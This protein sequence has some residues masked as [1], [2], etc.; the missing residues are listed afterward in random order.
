MKR[1]IYLLLCMYTLCAW[2]GAWVHWCI[3]AWVNAHRRGWQAEYGDAEC[4]PLP[5]STYSFE[6]ESFPE[7]GVHT[8]SAMLQ[9]SKP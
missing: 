3:G 8:F 2:M 6:A 1:F 7:L 4:S 9:A 5:L